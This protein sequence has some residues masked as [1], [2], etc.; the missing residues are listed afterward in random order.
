[1][2]TA[3]AISYEVITSCPDS[4]FAW[5][6]RST[7]GRAMLTIEESRIDMNDPIVVTA[8]GSQ[9]GSNPDRR[10]TEV[11]GVGG[12]EVADTGESNPQGSVAG[13]HRP[14]GFGVQIEATAGSAKYHVNVKIRVL[15]LFH[16]LSGS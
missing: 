3:N 7:L 2:T 1:M 5:K 4:R 8:S 9:R 15:R 12:A 6:S 11:A 16:R 13:E 14:G 10:A